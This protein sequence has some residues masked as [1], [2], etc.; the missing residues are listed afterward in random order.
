MLRR[1]VGDVEKIFRE[2]KE[3]F[4][5]NNNN[6]LQLDLS[7][8]LKN[9]EEVPYMLKDEYENDLNIIKIHNVIRMRFGSLLGKTEMLKTAISD[10]KT[11]LLQ[12]QISIVQKNEIKKEIINLEVELTDLETGKRWLEYVKK[13]KFFLEN[14]ISLASSESKGK[15]CIGKKE[16]EFSEEDISSRLCIIQGYLEVA[17]QYIELD[18]LWKG[19]SEL[20]CPNC[21]IK[22]N[23][24]ELDKNFGTYKCSCGY[25]FDNLD[26]NTHFNS[27]GFVNITNKNYSSYENYEKTFIRWEGNST[28]SI[29]GKLFTKLD[30]YFKSKKL[31]VGE[32]IRELPLL[33]DGKKKGTSIALLVAALDNSGNSSFYYLIFP[34]V[35]IYWGW[36]RPC[37]PDNIFYNGNLK[38]VILS[39]YNE[40]QKEYHI[41][42]TRDSCLNV[43]IMLYFLLQSEN[44]P[45]EQEDFKFL[46]TRE[47]ME[48]HHDMLKQICEKIGIKFTPLI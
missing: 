2:K 1:Q 11:I 6:V 25:T 23:E 30:E 38:N 31:P 46:I 15:L 8:P 14:Y 19:F 43:Q 21:G 20:N 40:I 29:N 42:K 3:K 41:I 34:I 26:K 45:C 44:Y 39:K 37:S 16:E 4:S 35:Y 33:N 9:N 32:D 24:Q 47:C 7:I 13:S 36:R 17:K 10:L 12:K 48:Y 18:I 27:D 5:F 28:D 22:M